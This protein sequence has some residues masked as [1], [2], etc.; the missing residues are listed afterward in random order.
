MGPVGLRPIASSTATRH[1]RRMAAASHISQTRP[2]ES[3]G[4]FLTLS[5]ESDG[6]EPHVSGSAHL[7]TGA[8]PQ[9][10]PDGVRL[11]V[12]TYGS[13]IRL[14]GIFGDALNLIMSK[15]TGQGSTPSPK[16]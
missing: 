3:I 8:A 13:E 11:A 7:L 10:S 16:G 9:W 14:G 2:P 12:L 5:A 4:G 1:S 6:A 15:T